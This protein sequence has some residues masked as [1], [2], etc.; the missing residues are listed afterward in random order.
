MADLCSIIES[1]AMPDMVETKQ[2]P[3]NS[4]SEKCLEPLFL[5]RIVF[6]TGIFTQSPKNR[7]SCSISSNWQC[8]EQIIKGMDCRLLKEMPEGP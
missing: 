5:S 1:V 3:W 2:F 8:L 4:V 6:P 7:R